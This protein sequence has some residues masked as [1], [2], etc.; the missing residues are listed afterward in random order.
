MTPLAT[1]KSTGDSASSTTSGAAAA[2]NSR[3]DGPS[4]KLAHSSDCSS[5]SST[6]SK[7]T[8][9]RK[10]ALRKLYTRG[11]AHRL[12]HQPD[13]HGDGPGQSQGLGHR[14]SGSAA[15]D[16]NTVITSASGSS[17]S[18][19]LR[20]DAGATGA[21]SCG[22][23]AVAA[24]CH[25]RKSPVDAGAKV[26]KEETEELET[27]QQ[28]E[29][30]GAGAQDDSPQVAL[31]WI[32][33][34]I[35]LQQYHLLNGDVNVSSKGPRKNKKLAKWVGQQKKEYWKWRAIQ[36]KKEQGLVSSVLCS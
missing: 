32:K 33:N 4:N 19:P 20:D 24:D 9:K 23:S 28:R 3:R 12:S 17:G 35:E 2:A 16:T 30:R 6:S 13:G 26:K 14:S 11:K 1:N 34:Y 27:Q 21:G 7:R 25:G 22:K 31:S 10:M 5:S 36:Q 15:D 18:N 29:H 8:R